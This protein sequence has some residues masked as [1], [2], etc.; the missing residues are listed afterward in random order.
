M[1]QYQ[2]HTAW[3]NSDELAKEVQKRF[4][5]TIGLEVFITEREVSE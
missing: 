3:L 4:Q 1:K 5:D 2:V